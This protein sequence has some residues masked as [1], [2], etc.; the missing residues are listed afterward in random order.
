MVPHP[1]HEARLPDRETLTGIHK[2]EIVRNHGGRVHLWMP[3]LRHV[4]NFRRTSSQRMVR[5]LRPDQ[6]GIGPLYL[7]SDFGT[8]RGQHELWRVK[9]EFITKVERRRLAGPRPAG[10]PGRQAAPDPLMTDMNLRISVIRSK[11]DG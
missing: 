10:S 9:M 1:K 11:S 7:R 4:G 8:P 2:D 5:S 3:N 6:Q